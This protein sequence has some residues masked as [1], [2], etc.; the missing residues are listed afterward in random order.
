[1]LRPGS[2]AV[3]LCDERALSDAAEQQMSLLARHVDLLLIPVCD[4]LDHALPAA[5]LLRFAQFGARLELDTHDA[6]LRQAYRLQG[7][8]RSARWK[9][10]AD[11]LRLPLM[12]LDTQRELVEQMREHLIGQHQ[13]ALR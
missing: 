9:R 10:L 12:P 7:E 6:A 3:I 8:A 5:G 1:V 13:G 4:P 2:L 11:R